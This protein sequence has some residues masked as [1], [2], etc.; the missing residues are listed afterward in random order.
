MLGSF[1]LKVNQ[2]TILTVAVDL[3]TYGARLKTK[4]KITNQLG[5]GLKRLTK[6][7]LIRLGFLRVVFMGVINLPPP[8]SPSSPLPGHILRRTYLISI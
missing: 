7:T 2:K 4:A 3:L 1:A 6:L 5:P 8:S